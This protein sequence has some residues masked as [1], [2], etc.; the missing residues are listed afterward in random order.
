MVCASACRQAAGLEQHRPGRERRWP[1]ATIGRPAVCW[2]VHLRVLG[3]GECNGQRLCATRATLRGFGSDSWT[4]LP[5]KRTA[6]QGRCKNGRNSPY[7]S[8]TGIVSAAYKD[9]TRDNGALVAATQTHGGCDNLPTNFPNPGTYCR[10]GACLL[11]TCGDLT[12]S[13]WIIPGCFK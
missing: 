1:R 3:G 6:A 11:K 9:L 12:S 13:C 7:L 4:G 2:T 8:L 5:R 10:R